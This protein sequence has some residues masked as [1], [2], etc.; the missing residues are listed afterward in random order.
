MKSTPAAEVVSA[1]QLTF[2]VAALLADNLFCS[3]RRSHLSTLAEFL[4]FVSSLSSDDK[5]KGK[6]PATVNGS[7]Q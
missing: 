1:W 6:R 3:A 2:A 5:G 7:A 4:A